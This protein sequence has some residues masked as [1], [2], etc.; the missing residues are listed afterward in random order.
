VKYLSGEPFS[1]SLGGTKDWD[2]NWERTFGKKAECTPECPFQDA[3]TPVQKVEI[4]IDCHNADPNRVARKTLE[5]L[6]GLKRNPQ[7]RSQDKLFDFTEGREVSDIR[8]QV[9][10][11]HRAI[12]QPVLDYP[13]VPD[14]DRVRFR[15][16]LV[17]EEFCEFLGATTGVPRDKIKEGVAALLEVL[18]TARVQ[19]DLVELADALADLDYVIEGTR[20]AFGINGKPIANEVHRSNMAKLGGGVNEVGKSLKPAGWTPPNIEGELIK[21][22]MPA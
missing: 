22:G 20:L 12:G 7:P 11:F 21:Q 8:K 6:E 17:L 18:K 1:V 2:D 13:Q 4:K 14:D 16:G 3:T 9:E 10:E 19:V 15:I 5:I